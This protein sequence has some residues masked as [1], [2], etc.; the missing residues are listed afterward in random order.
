[1]SR[2]ITMMSA[3]KLIE[4][5]AAGTLSPVDAVTATFE[6]ISK[7]NKAFNAF[8]HIDEDA[9]LTAARASEARWRKGTPIGMVDGV[10]T[11]IKDLAEVKFQAGRSGA[12]PKPATPISEV[13][14]ILPLLPVC[15]TMARCL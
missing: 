15:A 11:T 4:A 13:R 3:T 14:R 8:V 12:A 10:P 7:H 1:M 5:Y 2:D 6:K 9:A